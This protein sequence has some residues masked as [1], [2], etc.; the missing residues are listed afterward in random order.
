MLQLKT[1]LTIF[2]GALL[3]A[4]TELAFAQAQPARTPISSNAI[5]DK[6]QFELDFWKSTERIDTPAAYSAYLETFPNGRFA[7][8]ARA[9]MGKGQAPV[10]KEP[11][12]VPKEQPLGQIN[13]VVPTVAKLEP[14]AKLATY[15]EETNTGSVDLRAGDKLNGPIT[16]MVGGLGAKKQILIPK[17]E[18]VVL[19]ATDYD[20]IASIIPL[21]GGA[22]P[23]QRVRLTTVA[24]AQFDGERA[25]SLITFEYNRSTASS[26]INMWPDSVKCE[27]SEATSIYHNKEGDFTLE[28]CVIVHA[29]P[30]KPLRES[31]VP[32][33]WRDIDAS[34]RGLGGILGQFNIESSISII[35]QKAYLRVSRFDCTQLT[36]DGR[37]CIPLL[38]HS[39]RLALK[40]PGVESRIAWAK[41]YL[42]F[43]VT[44]FKR[45]LDDEDS[46]KTSQ[47][48]SLL[49][50]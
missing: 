44:G 46:L 42:P 49:P 21:T 37:G 22:S 43:V 28:R 8:L 7:A 4:G 16:L 2:L 24:L 26:L 11:A 47:A 33:V 38:D 45:D 17:G 39:R 5:T 20:K 19:A 9:A 13:S 27:G 3:F 18:W 35:T 32:A 48:M 30:D 23:N 40:A 10:S 36:S 6:G 34:M 41:A 25:A 12:P 15:S 1:G 31:A 14:R 29:L 50:D